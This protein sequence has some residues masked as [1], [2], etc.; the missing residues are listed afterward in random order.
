MDKSTT[1]ASTTRQDSAQNVSALG[2]TDLFI[3]TIITQRDF[4][5]TISFGYLPS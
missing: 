1:Q 5:F 2:M 4:P 3:D